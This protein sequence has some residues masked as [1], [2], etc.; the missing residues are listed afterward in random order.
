M[1]ASEQIYLRSG[2]AGRAPFL[3]IANKFAPTLWRWGSAAVD[4]AVHFEGGA[5]ADEPVGG[6]AGIDGKKEISGQSR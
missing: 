2:P 3:G 4:A 1:S 5:G 6:C